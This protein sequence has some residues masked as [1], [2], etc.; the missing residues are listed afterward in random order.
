MYQEQSVTVATDCVIE[1][2]LSRATWQDLPT[3]TRLGTMPYGSCA[4]LTSSFFETDKNGNVWIDLKRAIGGKTWICG[5]SVE[6]KEEKNTQHWCLDRLA[7]GEFVCTD[8]GNSYVPDILIAKKVDTKGKTKLLRHNINVCVPD[9]YYSKKELMHFHS[10][11][12]PYGSKKMITEYGFVDTSGHMHKPYPSPHRKP[13]EHIE[14]S[15]NEPVKY[16]GAFFIGNF[17]RHTVIGS[18]IV[19]LMHPKND[20]I[21]QLRRCLNMALT[22]PL[23]EMPLHI[24]DTFWLIAS[25]AKWRLEVG[26]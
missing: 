6:W 10:V 22:I 4:Y 2:A 11:F 14:F 5:N 18:T 3:N 1:T 24:N 13:P 9:I 7:T 20:L 21:Q 8:N 25:V 15:F 12:K 23:D 26:K 19:S 16:D 17:I